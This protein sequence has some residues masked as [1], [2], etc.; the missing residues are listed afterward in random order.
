MDYARSRGSRR[1]EEFR[2]DFVNRVL[3]MSI[4]LMLS[5]QNRWLVQGRREQ[6]YE[7]V[8]ISLLASAHYPRLFSIV[9][10]YLVTRLARVRQVLMTHNKRNCFF[11]TILF[12]D[13]LKGY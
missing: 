3:E 7:G 6:R 13:L 1:R 9:S 5:V 4:F 11:G 10:I 2:I 8:M 12:S